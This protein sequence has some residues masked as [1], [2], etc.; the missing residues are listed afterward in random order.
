[1]SHAL[2]LSATK[3]TAD[4]SNRPTASQAIKLRLQWKLRDLKLCKGQDKLI[5]IFFKEA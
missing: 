4:N 1:V 5:E 3:E 2:R